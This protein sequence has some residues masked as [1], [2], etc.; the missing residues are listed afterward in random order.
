MFEGI[1]CNVENEFLDAGEIAYTPSGVEIHIKKPDARTGHDLDGLPAKKIDD[2][3][4]I[5]TP[6]IQNS[7]Y[8][9]KT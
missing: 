8:I 3:W 5:Q 7:D 2:R 9:S 4:V 6:D 1:F